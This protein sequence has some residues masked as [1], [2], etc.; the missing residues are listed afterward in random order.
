MAKTYTIRFT[1]IVLLLI[2]I[3][4]IYL[5]FALVDSRPTEE[6]KECEE[7]KRNFIPVERS[8]ENAKEAYQED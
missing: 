8:E 2:G 4:Y 6:C 3:A 5:A 1:N 7:S